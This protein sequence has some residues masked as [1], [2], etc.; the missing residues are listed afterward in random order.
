[1][2]PIEGGE[3]GT[4]R[5]GTEAMGDP[6]VPGPSLDLAYTARWAACCL[7]RQAGARGTGTAL[8]AVRG[9]QGGVHLCT[10][11]GRSQG[12]VDCKHITTFH[13]LDPSRVTLQ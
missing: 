8:A 13:P 3:V 9:E 4:H 6:A 2:G 12:A 7:A 11:R 1:M 5:E 10:E